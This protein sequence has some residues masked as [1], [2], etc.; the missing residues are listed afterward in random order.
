VDWKILQKLPREYHVAV[1]AVPKKTIDPIVSSLIAVGLKPLR[2]KPDASTIAKL[3]A[4]PPDSHAIV[5]E[6]NKSFAYV[7][8]VDGEKAMFTTVVT[9]SPGDT[10]TTYL[11]NIKQ[12][13]AEI[14]QYYK[15]KQVIKEDTVRILLTGEVA[16]D[17]W[18]K[19]LPPPASVLLTPIRNPGFN[20]AYA[21]ALPQML[22]MAEEET[23]N[24]LPKQMQDYYDS[25]RSNL[26]TKRCYFAPHHFW[27]PVYF[28]LDLCWRL[29]L[30]SDKT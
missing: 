12:T 28:L 14:T 27:V 18:V 24:L 17:Y 2:L 13:I 6:V 26:Y 16:N 29:L 15:R 11:T 19:E 3:L 25:E 22:Q 9:F 8:F 10:P 30:W 20:K 7:T 21:T 4:L 23:I 1:A 5:T